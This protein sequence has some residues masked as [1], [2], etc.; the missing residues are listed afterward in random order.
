MEQLRV[1]ISDVEAFFLVVDT[2]SFQKAA[3][4]LNTSKSKISRQVARLEDALQVRL[5]TRSTKGVQLT[6]AGMRY[7]A[8]AKAAL[9]E[10]EAAAEDVMTSAADIAGPIR[11]TGPASFGII[12]LADSLM[13]FAVLHPRVEL[14]IVFTDQR[15]DLIKG[16]FDI[17]VRIGRL[18]DSSLVSRSLANLSNMTV[19]SPAYLERMG[20]PSIPEEL[21]AH[22]GIYYANTGPADMWRYDIGGRSSAIRVP[23]RMRADNGETMLKAAVAGLGV[24]R[25]PGFIVREALAA[26]LVEPI[27][28]D[29][30]SA[31]TGMHILMPQGRSQI[32]RVRALVDFLLAKYRSVQ[33]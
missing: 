33:L 31:G 24:A 14:D 22:Q 3:E 29:F 26:G 6:D 8:R 19:A 18:E 5:L 12:H 15:V 10:L 9:G 4:R 17:G 1:N 25:M 21:V 11:I 16:G 7:H 20:R 23:V 30:E 28:V 32:A 13:E 27:L 2:G